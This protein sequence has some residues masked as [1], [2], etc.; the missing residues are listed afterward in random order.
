MFADLFTKP[1][2]GSAFQ[3]F[4][5]AVLNM[6]SNFNDQVE[7][8]VNRSQECVEDCASGLCGARENV[9]EAKKDAWNKEMSDGA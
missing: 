6:Q 2:Q 1:L 4:C 5:N 9:E 3:K 8:H 7:N